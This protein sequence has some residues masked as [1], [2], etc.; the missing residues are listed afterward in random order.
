MKYL[1]E[2]QNLNVRLLKV[3]QKRNIDF[4]IACWCAIKVHLAGAKQCSSFSYY[5]H[6]FLVVYVRFINCF[7]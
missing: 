5:D 2:M 4:N 3:Q 7:C 6:L 1:F